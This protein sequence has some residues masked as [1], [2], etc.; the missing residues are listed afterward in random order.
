MCFIIKGLI[1]NGRSVFLVAMLLLF[2]FPFSVSGSDELKEAPRQDVL[3]RLEELEEQLLEMQ[4]KESGKVPVTAFDSIKLDF[5]GFIT[6]TFTSNFNGDS[7]D[8][9]S[10]DQTNLEILIGADITENH[11][12]FTAV[13]YLPEDYFKNLAASSKNKIKAVLKVK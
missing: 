1:Q 9:S 4:L 2:A 11:R 10:F 12:F 6:Q 13:G 3:K 5:G 8:R 7:P